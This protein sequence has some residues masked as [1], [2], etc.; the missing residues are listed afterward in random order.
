MLALTTN[1][2]RLK[3]LAR[4]LSGAGVRRLNVSLSSLRRER[5][6]R[7]TGE[8]LLPEVMAGIDEA[9]GAGF[10]P[11]KLNTVIMSGVNDDELLD[12][13]DLARIRPVDVRFIEF[14]PFKN[15]GWKEERF[16]PGTA[17]MEAIAAV[18]PLIPAG[19]LGSTGVA[20]EFTIPGWLGRI[21]FVTPL[22]DGFCRQCNRLRLTARGQ[23]MTC[24]YS[25]PEVDLRSA[26]RRGASD[27]TLE[28][29]ILEAV[30]RKPK[31]H[32]P[33]RELVG[34]ATIPMNVI[35]G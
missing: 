9:I 4:S 32:S 15:N 29:M 2:V 26:L 17:I 28:P 11:L 6:A 30:G 10:V 7:V 14:M 3:S 34:G 27:G 5:F 18:H 35:G 1:G 33:M 21:S 12:L 24:L 23:L 19:K 31:G 8:D 22:S 25:E 20:K 13:V 16:L